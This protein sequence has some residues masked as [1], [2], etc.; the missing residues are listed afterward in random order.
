MLILLAGLCAGARSRAAEPADALAMASG[1][2]WRE[3]QRHH[4][5]PVGEHAWTTRFTFANPTAE[6]VTIRS[7]QPSCG[8]TSPS[9]PHL[10]W[11]IAPGAA[12]HLDVTVDFTGKEGELT[13]TIA[14]ITDRGTD[15]LELTLTVPPP[16]PAMARRRE[17]NRTIARADP[18]AVFRGDCARCHAEPAHD[19]T[20]ADL[21]VA[22]CAVCHDSPH[23]A[24]MVPL[25]GMPGLSRDPA[26]WRATITD[27]RP[28][29]LMPAFARAHGGPLSDAQI[30]SLVDFLRRAFPPVSPP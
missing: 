1:L 6:T 5:A 25:L 17:Q 8:C 19:L 20:G 24:S 11:N 15:T 29:K 30:D 13:K 18:Q 7:I 23:R 27:G 2:R 21:Y 14:V 28:G 9:V 22:V 26:F 3:P 10:P 4:D 12:E 16:D